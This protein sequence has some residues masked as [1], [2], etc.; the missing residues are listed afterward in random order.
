MNFK[1]KKVFFKRLLRKKK[2][3]KSEKKNFFSPINIALKLF[4]N[5]SSKRFNHLISCKTISITIER[6]SLDFS[7]TNNY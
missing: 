2:G 7:T 3:F 4:L 1:K 6:E 5:N